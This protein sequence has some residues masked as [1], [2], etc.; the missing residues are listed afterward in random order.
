MPVV[1][2]GS[3]YTT[4]VEDLAAGRRYEH[5]HFDTSSM[6]HFRA[7]ETASRAARRRARPVRKRIAVPRHPVVDQRDPRRRT[8]RTTPSARSWPAT[9]RVCSACASRRRGAAPTSSGRPGRIDVHTHSGPIPWDVPDTRGRR[10][11][12][13]ARRR[14]RDAVTPSPR[15]C[16]PSRPTSRPATAATVE[17]C[18]RNEGLLG[19]LVADPERH[20]GVA[21]H[22]AA[23]GR[24][25]GHRRGQGPHGVVAP[26]HRQP[27]DRG[28]VR[29]PRRPRPAGQDPQR[30]SRLGPAPAPDRARRI[31]KPADHHRPRR[32]RLTRMSRA[33][34][35][36]P[37]PTTSTPRCRRASPSSPTVREFMRTIPK[38]KMLFGTDAPLL[39]PGVRPRDLPGRGDPRGRPG[40]AVYWDNAARLFGVG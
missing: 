13:G 8:S 19:Y 18:A 29:R 33:P 32:T 31:R 39:D 12:A 10:A 20:R 28:A 21:R 26:A 24:R 2:T 23:L 15:T 34:G 16:S 6:A 30:R 25:A 22:P 7:I 11:H 40:P 5:L 35:S 38:D 37:R 9:R 4:S 17:A 1:L 36:R 27:G 14:Q 3:H